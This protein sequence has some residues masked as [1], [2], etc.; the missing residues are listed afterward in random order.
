MHCKLQFQSTNPKKSIESFIFSRSTSIFHSIKKRK[1][2]KTFLKFFI[3]FIYPSSFFFSEEA[4]FSTIWQNS[5]WA[6][7]KK[8]K[9]NMNLI[10]Q[11]THTHSTYSHTYTRC[12]NT[13]YTHTRCVVRATE[14][15][16]DSFTAVVG[17][18]Q[19]YACHHC[20]LHILGFLL[21]LRCIKNASLWTKL[22]KINQSSIFFSR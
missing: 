9:R 12:V 17:A 4:H 11:N 19:F 16:N 13:L 2:N 10:W 8:L 5:C 20:L 22:V 21:C 6:T 15:A 1:T 3:H 18:S 7:S 14:T